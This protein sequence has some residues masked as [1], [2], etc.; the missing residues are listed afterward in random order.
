MKFLTSKLRSLHSCFFQSF[1]PRISLTKIAKQNVKQIS[2]E[3]NF[4]LLRDDNKRRKEKNSN[5]LN[6]KCWEIRSFK[7]FNDTILRLPHGEPQELFGSKDIK[8]GARYR[9]GGNS[10]ETPLEIQFGLASSR[11]RCSGQ[12]AKIENDAASEQREL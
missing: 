3:K 8:T 10:V 6:S 12:K 9:C 11:E 1:N 7:L 5:L 2:S 4:S